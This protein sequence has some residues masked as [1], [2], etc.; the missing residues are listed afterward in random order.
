MQKP[1]KKSS[2]DVERFCD[3]LIA[4]YTEE[5][6][7]KD[8][9]INRLNFLTK[10]I[11]EEK[12][13]LDNIN[14]CLEKL[15]FDAKLKIETYKAIAYEI[16]GVL[17]ER[18][19][20]SRS[21][22]QSAFIAAIKKDNLKKEEKKTGY[23]SKKKK[24]QAGVQEIQ[25]GEMKIEKKDMTTKDMSKQLEEEE[26]LK[27]ELE[28]KREEEVKAA[29]L[30]RKRFGD[31]YRL[32]FTLFSSVVKMKN[33]N[34]D[35]NYNKLSEHIVELGHPELSFRQQAAEKLIGFSNLN[36]AVDPLIASLKDKNLVFQVVQAISKTT[37]FRSVLPL[38][39]TVNEFPGDKGSFIRGEI[40]ST[41]GKI[42]FGLNKKEKNSGTVK[43]Y[44]LAKHPNFEGKLKGIIPILKKDIQSD[45]MRKEYFSPQC[46]KLLSVVGNKLYETKKKT[47]K[48]LVINLTKDTPLS[49]QIKEFNKILEEYC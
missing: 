28:A 34:G 7:K 8:S 36:L 27:E 22:S 3:F 33:K 29:E 1:V 41:I 35:E 26:K 49:R 4:N 12:V 48:V 38:I 2:E 11:I 5:K 32:A 6:I 20:R 10:S 23:V 30:E 14:E 45:D 42:I 25:P 21:R 31:A 46:I 16:L 24:E 40:Y 47:S 18:M 17:Q 39:N 13:N 19:L 15:K 43:F 9:K 44:S 37:D